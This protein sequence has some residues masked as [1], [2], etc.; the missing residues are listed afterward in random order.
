MVESIGTPW[1]WGGFLAFVV[2]M[3]ALDLGVFHRRPHEVRVGEALAWSVVWV[4]LALVFNAWIYWRFGREIGLE[5]LTGYLIEKSLSVDNVFVFVLLFTSFGVPRH[6]QHR[7]LFWGIFGALV[8]RV[9]F[10]LFGA[11]LLQRFHWV[12]YVFGA[13]LVYSGYR[14]LTH[15]SGEI[16]PEKNPIYRLF[17]RLLPTVPAFEDGRFTVVRA[18]RR[19]ATPLLLVLIAIE[20]TDVVFAVDSIPAIFGI[21]DDPFIVFTSNIF[22]IL[23]LRALYF[24]LGGFLGRFRYLDEG[25]ALVLLFVGGKMLLAGV[26]HVPTPV[27]LLVI[28]VVIG[29][30]IGLSL[31][32]RDQ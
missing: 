20:A 28:A 8:M 21:T 6:L 23:G 13:I 1:L 17:A 9:V 4:G 14:F 3:L 11:L 22:A 16:H 27:S 15:E 25:L 30:A 12:I 2:A 26:V 19:H 31:L 29:G 5:F 18:G 7:V 24:V 10:I 32:R